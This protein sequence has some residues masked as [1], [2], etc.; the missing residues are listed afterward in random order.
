MNK[1][2]FWVGISMC[3][4]NLVGIGAFIGLPYMSN[5]NPTQLIAMSI[6]GLFTLVSLALVFIGSISE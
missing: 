5:I 1:R 6:Y 2:I 4:L 3:L